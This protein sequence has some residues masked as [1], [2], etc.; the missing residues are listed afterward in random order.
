MQDNNEEEYFTFKK[1]GNG[2][3]GP[4]RARN[5]IA[6]GINGGINLMDDNARQSVD[7]I[8][9]LEK[10]NCDFSAFDRLHRPRKQRI[11]SLSILTSYH[12]NV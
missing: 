7:Y 6:N 8:A 4:S 5:A 12:S 9:K 11:I 3:Q 1:D 10:V 2:G